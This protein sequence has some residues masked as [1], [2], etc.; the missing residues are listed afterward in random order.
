MLVAALLGALLMVLSDWLGR[1]V[2]FPQQMP[3]GILAT[4]IGGPYLMWLLRRH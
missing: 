2:V 3:A 1:N 4:L